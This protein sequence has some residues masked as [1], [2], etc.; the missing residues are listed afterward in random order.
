MGREERSRNETRQK[1]CERADKLSNFR[2]T[3]VNQIIMTP[4]LQLKEA[5]ILQVP[6]LT[7]LFGKRYNI[8]RLA[9]WS[10]NDASCAPVL[11]DHAVS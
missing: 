7:L 8:C 2:G 3:T 11:S 5:A 10:V 4:C 6:Y 9:P 1:S